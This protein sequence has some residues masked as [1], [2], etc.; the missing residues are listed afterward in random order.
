[1]YCFVFCAVATERLGLLY[2]MLFFCVCIA[3]NQTC[4]NP[5]RDPAAEEEGETAYYSLPFY[6]Q[7]T[8]ALCLR[9]TG[10][11]TLAQHHLCLLP[12][13]TMT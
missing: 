2:F 11:C 4:S 3:P 6:S 8:A 9:C 12:A 1:M 5:G 13:R 7:H 10:A